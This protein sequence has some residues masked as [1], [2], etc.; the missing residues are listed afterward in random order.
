MVRNIN[1][2]IEPNKIYGLIGR[3][4]AGKTTFLK[5]VARLQN[6]RKGEIFFEGRRIYK[7]DYLDLDVT[8]IGD[9]H[10]FFKI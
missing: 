1:L 3:N 6:E 5:T 8:F 2:S 4:G 7:K 10:A 9:E